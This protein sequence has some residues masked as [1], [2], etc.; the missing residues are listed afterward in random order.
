MPT[1][2]LLTAKARSISLREVYCA[3]EEAAWNLFKE[4]RWPET[5]GTPVCPKCGCTESY[6][7]ATRRKHKCKACHH[8]YSVTSGTILASRKMSFTDLLAAIVIIINGAKGV[9]ALQLARDLPHLTPLRRP[10]PDGFHTNWFTVHGSRFTVHNRRVHSAK[11]KVQSAEC[12]M[13]HAVYFALCPLHF[14]LR[15]SSSREP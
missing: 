4:M 5:N 3:G 9:S 2:F 6:E 8:Q 15:F 10:D 1:H 11:G 7:I 12:Q 13:R 14:V